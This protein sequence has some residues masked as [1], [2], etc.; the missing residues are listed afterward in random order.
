MAQHLAG[1]QIMGGQMGMGTGSCSDTE[2]DSKL[3]IT[4]EKSH[5]ML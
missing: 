5:K 2:V 4:I 1:K 3:V